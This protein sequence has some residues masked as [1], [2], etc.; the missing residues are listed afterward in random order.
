MT[1]FTNDELTL[2]SLYSPGSRKGTVEELCLM[3]DYL[4][5]DET[6]LESLAERTLTKLES[7]TDEE[8]SHIHKHLIPNIPPSIPGIPDHD[9]T[10]S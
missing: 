4:L 9:R 3:M 8:F 5:P 1:R 7:M 6:E 10:G 2:V